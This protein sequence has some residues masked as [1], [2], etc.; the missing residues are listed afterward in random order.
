MFLLYLRPHQVRCKTRVLQY[1]WTAHLFLSSW[2][3]S[4]TSWCMKLDT[5]SLRSII[6]GVYFTQIDDTYYGLEG[7]EVE[8]G[9][10]IC[11][12]PAF[13]HQSELLVLLISAWNLTHRVENIKIHKFFM[14]FYKLGTLH[15]AY[16]IRPQ[17]SVEFDLSHFF[18][19][20]PTLWEK[21]AKFITLN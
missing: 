21:V 17:I 15:V 4:S 6:S 16:S 9:C 19:V 13:L 3:F 1:I 7:V 20:R 14:E 10:Y 18:K 12:L 2:T 5:S 8:R 11:G